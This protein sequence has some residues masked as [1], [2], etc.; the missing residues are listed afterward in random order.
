MHEH[1][2]AK[3]RKVLRLE[4]HASRL[5]AHYE[6]ALAEVSPGKHKAEQLLHRARALKVT[7]TP[8]ELSE[9][10]SARNGI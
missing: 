2:S 7:L 6:G 3:V 4:G 9:L 10:R 5:L 1:R 8:A